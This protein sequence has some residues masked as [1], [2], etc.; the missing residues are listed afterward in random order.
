MTATWPLVL[1]SSSLPV[2]APVPDF[3][4]L[5][6]FHNSHL[7]DHHLYRLEMPPVGQV[8]PGAFLCFAGAV[9]LV[10]VCVNHTSVVRAKS[11]C[12]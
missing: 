10:F 3:V 2:R 7:P 6:S 4:P 8:I 5:D 12:P 9:L 11:L 1:H